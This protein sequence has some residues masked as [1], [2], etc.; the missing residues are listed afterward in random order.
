MIMVYPGA[1]NGNPAR[2]RTRTRVWGPPTGRPPHDGTD[3]LMV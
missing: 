1:A 3:Y 2:A